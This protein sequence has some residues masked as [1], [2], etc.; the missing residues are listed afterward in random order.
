[1][2]LIF[3]NCEESCWKLCPRLSLPASVY[4]TEAEILF[5]HRVKPPEAV[6][7][8]CYT[9]GECELKKNEENLE[10][11]EQ[12]VLAENT[13]CYGYENNILGTAL[14]LRIA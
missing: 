8:P 14:C 10:K 6:I 13:T 9:V 11:S 4:V 7:P 5:L 1:M 3:F 2:K 12:Q